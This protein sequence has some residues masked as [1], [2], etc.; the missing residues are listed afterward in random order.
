M[1]SRTLLAAL[2]LAVGIAVPA[3]AHHSFAMFD[4][5]VQLEVEGVV[6]DFQFTNPHSW[7]Q[8]MVTPAG[9]GAAAEWSIEA[10]SPNV[11]GRA[12]WKKNTLKPGDR[13]KVLVNPLRNGS[14]GGNLVLVTL[15]DGTT[16]GGGA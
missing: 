12:G 5:T 16:L 13:V 9:G 6:K 4:R 3:S 11:L 2:L 15:P 7:I 8:L 14:P 10:L 1:R